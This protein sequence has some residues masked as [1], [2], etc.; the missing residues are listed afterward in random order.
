MSYGIA[1][2][3]VTIENLGS[4]IKTSI[5]TG[6]YKGGIELN[7]YFSKNYN[8]LKYPKADE[9]AGG[10]RNAQLGAIHSI[11]SFFT[12]NKTKAAVVVMPTG[13]G[14]TAVLM[15]TPY[16]LEANKVLVITPSKLVRSQVS[17]EYSTLKKIGRAHV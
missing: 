8:K 1:D 3:F 17:G 7:S 2:K 4:Y 5:G 14:K 6:A 11:S 16:V 12:L 15:M 13:S 9:E 10:L